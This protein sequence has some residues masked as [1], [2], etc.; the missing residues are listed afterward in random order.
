MYQSYWRFVSLSTVEGTLRSMLRL[1]RSL[2]L[3]CA[4]FPAWLV[5]QDTTRVIVEGTLVNAITGVPVGGAEVSL[6]ELDVHL[7]T[8]SEG[9]FRLTDVALGTYWLSFAADGF[10]NAEREFQVDRAG[11]FVVRMEPLDHPEGKAFGQVRGT[12]RDGESG[13]VL[14]SVQIS[15]P[16]LART[17][18]SDS[19]GRFL[20]R[21]LPSGSF[22]MRTEHLGHGSRSDSVSVPPGQVVMVE[23]ELFVEPIELEALSVVVE[24]RPLSL[25]VT[26]FYDRL[27]ATSGIFLTQEEIEAK[28]PIFTTDV[29][30]SLPGVRV[31]GTG[32]LDRAVVLRGGMRGG[33][34]TSSLCG[35]TVYLDGFPIARG[36]P[37]SESAFLDRI[38][39]PS[40]IAGIEVY[41]SGA[42]AP[43]QYKG[44]GSDCGV[45]VIW[46]R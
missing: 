20:F 27:E 40:E 39:R 10:R 17:T 46:T 12:V 33:L 31:V 15:L 3:V 4:L 19:H 1:A 8:D 16:A 5:A 26:G 37:G 43:L 32:G 29:F 2:A 44:L 45:I 25:D 22:L 41:T 35:P 13:E 36:G 23:V 34:S 42:T 18:L 21:D 9:H 6:S 14:E 24:R 28:Q 11:S 7:V 30:N 38:V